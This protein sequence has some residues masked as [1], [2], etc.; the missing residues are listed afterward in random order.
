MKFIDRAFAIT[1]TAFA[2]GSVTGA[3]AIFTLQPF[4]TFVGALL[5][6]RLLAPVRE[7]SVFGSAAL[8]LLIFANNSATVLLSFLYPIILAKV[9]WT[10]TPPA[11]TMRHLLAWFSVLAGFLIGFFNLGATLTW[12]WESRGPTRFDRLLASSGLHGPFE[13][14]FILL[15]V[16]EPFR[17]TMTGVGWGELSSAIRKDWKLLCFC[18]IGLLISATVEVLVRV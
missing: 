12:A 11:K 7:V 14:L 18:L 13:F 1:L 5:L 10:P 17:L 2:L 6:A 3:L 4:K 16:A 9:R 15:A 8:V